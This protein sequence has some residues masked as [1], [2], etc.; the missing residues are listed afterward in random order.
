VKY[1]VNDY[2]L[3]QGAEMDGNDSDLDLDLNGQKASGG[4]GVRGLVKGIATGYDHPEY[5][6][7][8]FGH[9]RIGE[10]DPLADLGDYEDY[11]TSLGEESL[12]QQGQQQKKRKRLTTGG[13]GGA[14]KKDNG[15]VVGSTKRPKK[16]ITE[17]E[18]IVAYDSEGDQKG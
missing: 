18:K 8:A 4:E 1:F 14:R 9:Y 17:T 2:L 5:A 6:M 7:A 12:D 15:M 13:G 3:A 10:F 16:G 11:G